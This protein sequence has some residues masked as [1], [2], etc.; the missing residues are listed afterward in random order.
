[1]R[2]NKPFFTCYPMV[3][4][5]LCSSNSTFEQGTPL[6]GSDYAQPLA[7]A[8]IFSDNDEASTKLRTFFCQRRH[9]DLYRSSFGSLL[10]LWRR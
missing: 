1:M 6:S 9:I 2:G 4:H 3:E 10:L 5:V 7:S 8:I